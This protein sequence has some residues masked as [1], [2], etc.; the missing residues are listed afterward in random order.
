MWVVTALL[1]ENINKWISDKMFPLVPEKNIYVL[2]LYK[3]EE[4]ELLKIRNRKYLQQQKRGLGATTDI[5]R[6]IDQI[7]A[8]V[9]LHPKF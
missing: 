5:V 8:F 6:L 2:N 3:F 7:Q 9:E 4:L 1:C